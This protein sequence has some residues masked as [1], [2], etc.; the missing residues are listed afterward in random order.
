[1]FGE[2]E[3]LYELGSIGVEGN[4][5]HAWRCTICRYIY[6]PREGDRAKGATPGTPFE[7]LPAD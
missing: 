4:C 5:M 3:L 7:D 2:T 6:D 1:M